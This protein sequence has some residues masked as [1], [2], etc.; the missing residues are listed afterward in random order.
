MRAQFA[1]LVIAGLLG[2]H[3]GWSN[4]C[5]RHPHIIDSILAETHKSNCASIT[6]EDLAK[7]DTLYIGYEW[8]SEAT[9]GTYVMKGGSNLGKRSL[10]KDIIS[11]LRP[12][13]FAGLTK[14]KM[15]AIE[16]AEISSIEPGV[17]AQLGNSCDG[18]S[19]VTS[20]SLSHNKLKKVPAFAFENLG[21][22]TELEIDSQ[23]DRSDSMVSLIIEAGA[24][25][26]LPKVTSIDIDGGYMTQL[27]KD[28]LKENTQLRKLDLSGNLLTQVPTGIFYY[29]KE[30]C[31]VVEITY[32]VA[33]KKNVV[34]SL[35]K[36]RFK[37]FEN[38]YDIFADR[39]AGEYGTPL[40]V[41]KKNFIG[42]TG[43][44]EISSGGGCQ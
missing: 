40:K 42:I 12:E 23:N 13:W 31:G 7:V 30:N 1:L 39:L 19:C 2:S 29:L 5:D 34:A 11:Q 9:Y 32:S 20:L 21:N 3:N 37:Q 33:F 6:D 41:I 26:N 8:D 16:G 28:L 17:W 35:G 43:L 18:Q 38:A 14:L 4:I 27:P 25:D 24:F 10:K 22:L 44:S 36:A 15:L